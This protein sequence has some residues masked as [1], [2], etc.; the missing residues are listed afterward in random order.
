MEEYPKW[1]Y[2]ATE[3]PRLVQDPGQLD[4]LGNAW[5]ETP[6]AFESTSESGE[7]EAKRR[8]RPRKS[9]AEGGE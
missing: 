9:E 4:E 2:H 1:M 6:A 3:A 5:A 8:G 7:P